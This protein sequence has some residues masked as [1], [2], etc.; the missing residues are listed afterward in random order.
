MKK[1][2]RNFLTYV[3]ATIIMGCV[4]LGIAVF[5]GIT[6]ETES[7]DSQ[8]YSRNHECV[9]FISS[10]EEDEFG[11]KYLKQEFHYSDGHVIENVNYDW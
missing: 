8:Y 9:E 7:I 11:I 10:L 1:R 3:I 6:Y 2:I 5:I 4:M